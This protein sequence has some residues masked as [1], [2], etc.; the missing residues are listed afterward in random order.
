MKNR[1]AFLSD[2]LINFRYDNVVAEMQ[3]MFVPKQEDKSDVKKEYEHVL[4]EANHF[5]YE[6]ER[7]PLGVLVHCIELFMQHEAK[8]DDYAERWKGYWI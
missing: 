5:F 4:K 1:I 8:N 6:L 3:F 7:N 2:I